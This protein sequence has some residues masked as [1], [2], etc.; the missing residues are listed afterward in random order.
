MVP[1]YL[2]LLIECTDVEP[3]NIFFRPHNVNVA[4]EDE[5]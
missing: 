1:R 4:D 3:T 2:F 5:A